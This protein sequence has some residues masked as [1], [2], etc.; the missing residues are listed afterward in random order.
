MFQNATKKAQNKVTKGTLRVKLNNGQ[1]T[2]PMP[3]NYI[4]SWDAILTSSER[5]TFMSCSDKIA[6]WNAVG[7]QVCSTLKYLNKTDQFC[8]ILGFST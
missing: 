6:L 1:G 5:C 8:F 3:I 7:V 2:I 4:S